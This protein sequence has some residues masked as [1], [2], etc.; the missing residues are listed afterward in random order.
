MGATVLKPTVDDLRREREK[1]VAALAFSEETLRERAAD[2]LVTPEE[3]RILRRLDVIDFLL[4][5]DE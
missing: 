4:G 5:D 2:F 1:L 3:S